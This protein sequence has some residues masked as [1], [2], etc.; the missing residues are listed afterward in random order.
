MARNATKSPRPSQRQGDGSG[1]PALPDADREAAALSD[2][3]QSPTDLHALRAFIGALDISD[4]CRTRSEELDAALIT[5]LS[6]SEVDQGKVQYF[7]Q[8]CLVSDLSQVP[9]AGTVSRKTLALIAALLHHRFNTNL[10]LERALIALRRSL[11]TATLAGCAHDPS[12]LALAEAMAR[13]SF[14]NEYVWTE[15]AD[16]TADIAELTS[17]IDRAVSEGDRVPARD[18]YTL[19]AY[20][21]LDRIDSVRKWVA[22]IGCQDQQALDPTLRLLVFDRLV[23]AAL[24]IDTLTPIDDRV[25]RAVRTQY[26][27]N[28]YPRW[29]HIRQR[30]RLMASP[31]MSPLR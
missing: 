11:L 6:T 31:H 4:P 20:R 24:D 28:P 3:S 17:R 23:E 8:A 10:L 13:H 25:S 26:E 30:A 21:P 12:T 22:A 29:R 5:V 2:L 16:E 7:T 1:D 9:P 27:E 15:S 14:T 18:L 19:G